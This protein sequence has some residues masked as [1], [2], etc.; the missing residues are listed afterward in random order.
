ML[1][2]DAD[3]VELPH[4]V[5]LQVDSQPERPE[6]PYGFEHDARDADLMQRQGDSQSADAA[7]GHEDRSIC[8]ECAR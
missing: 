1:G 3:I 8:H 5:R 6:V 7:A 2:R 4:G